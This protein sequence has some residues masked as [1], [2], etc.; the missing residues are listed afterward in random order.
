MNITVVGPGALGCLLAARLHQA[1]GRRVRL[2]DHNPDR[3]EALNRQGII[4]EELPSAA[5]S[6]PA[7]SPPL[8]IPVSTAPATVTEAGAVLLCVKSFALESVL[9]A[10]IPHLR[11]ATLVVALPNG[12]GH[13]ESM[14]R[15]TGHCLPA[16][17]ISTEGATL[18]APGRVRAGGRGLTRLGYV[19]APKSNLA[20]SDPLIQIVSL[21]N[22][23]GLACTLS[24]DI[25]RDL[26]RKLLVN[27]GIN[28]LTVIHD[29]PNG[30]L[31]EIPE[32]REAMARAVLEAAAVA[33]AHGVSLEE[34][35][36][37]MVEEVCRN[38]AGNISSML[39]DIRRHRPTEI[40]A[41][42]GE[43]IRRADEL[44]LA[45]P[46][47]RRLVKAVDRLQAKSRPQ[48]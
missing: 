5:S 35:P 23:A 20:E 45:V 22:R 10:I 9:D 41:I 31:L 6:A 17:G 32:A 3:A 46:E 44:G 14:R 15:L 11:P 43:V 27:A 18:L 29:C 37:A 47:N 7:P 28:A 2:L 40:M 25:H 30:R 38:T 21:F 34:D 33:A 1:G 8:S 42:N 36:V 24:D 39:Q 4:I 16:L 12:I 19:E 48:S 26:W 13:L